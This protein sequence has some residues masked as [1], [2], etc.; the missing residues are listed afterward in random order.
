MNHAR[1]VIPRFSVVVVMATVLGLLGLI[2]AYVRAQTTTSALDVRITTQSTNRPTGGLITAVTVANIGTDVQSN[3][4]L[5]VRI[6]GLPALIQDVLQAATPFAD[7]GTRV[8][9]I[10]DKTGYWYHTIASV[11]PGSSVTYNVNWF[12]VCPGRWPFAARANQ[13]R[14]SASFQFTG[15]PTPGCGPDDVAAPTAAT[16]FELP[17]PPSVAATTSTTSTTLTPGVTTTI[18]GAVTSTIPGAPIATLPPAPTA[19]GASSTVAST[20]T[21]VAPPKP[22]TT[23]RPTT[24]PKITKPPTTL[25]I[26]CKTVAGRRYCGPKSS[27]L[28]PGQK[29][30]RDVKPPTTKKKKKT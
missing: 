10:E 17:W 12:N 27:A 20:S 22:T 9:V 19:P 13:V 7:S 26:V 15:N 3:V 5:V 16:W 28:K 29:K 8:G 21:T 18:P 23:R 4:Q 1:N 11:P 30:P 24:K 25:E 6:P 14:V 2:P